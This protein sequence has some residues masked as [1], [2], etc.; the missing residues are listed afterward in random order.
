MGEITGL[1]VQ[2]KDKT[3]CNVYVD[4]RFLCGLSV[5]VAMRNRLKVGMQV[6]TP[7]LEKIQLEGEK[8]VALSK[9]L[10]FVTVSQK[11]K[12]QVRDHLTKKGYL[13]VVIEYVLDKMSDYR[14]VDDSAY[15]GTYCEWAAK[16]KGKKL[17]E[18]E[19]RA[20]GVSEEDMTE[21]LEGVD[22]ESQKKTARTLLQ[23]YMRGKEPNKETLAKA[24]RH[25]LS[26]GFDYETARGALSALADE[27]ELQ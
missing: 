5:E 1:S 21:A 8:D 11:T 24:F 27:E 13:P 6:D 26:K 20:K 19:L 2:S 9:A 7:F 14:F 10:S 4:G 15:A 22:E 18:L 16:K 17:I 25:L 23:K 12:K 3:R